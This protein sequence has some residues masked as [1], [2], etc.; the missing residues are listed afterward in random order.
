MLSP[1]PSRLLAGVAHALDETVLPAME[2]GP[3]RNQLLAAIGIVR[4]CAA[5]VDAFGPTLH[6]ECADL[7][8]SLRSIVE[9]DARL[10]IDRASVDAALVTADEVLAQPY[11]AVPDLVAA[12]LALHQAAADV[13]VAA[14]RQRSTTRPAVRA[15]LQRMTD[16]QDALGLSPW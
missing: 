1:S 7:V 10:V 16:R 8:M 6:E 12:V 15:L 11:P 3:A 2:R 14:E 13:A 4:R 5:T 9:A